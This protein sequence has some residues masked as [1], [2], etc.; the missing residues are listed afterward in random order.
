MSEVDITAQ[1]YQ[2]AEAA[3]HLYRSVMEFNLAL[4]EA[5]QAGLKV[6]LS[7][8]HDFRIGSPDVGETL[9][10]KVWQRVPEP[11]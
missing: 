6:D 7:I 5:R 9:S 11:A 2:K 1:D 3:L 4:S 8:K 10:V